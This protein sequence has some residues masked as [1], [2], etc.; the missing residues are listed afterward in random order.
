MRLMPYLRILICGLALQFNAAP[1]L[2]NWIYTPGTGSAAFVSFNSG[3]TPAGTGLCAAANTDCTATVPINTAGA[4]LFTGTTP[5]IVAGGGT[6]G[7]PGTAVMA[8]QGVSGGT[9]VPVSATQTTSPWIIAGA[10][11]AGSPG[12]AALTIQGIGSGTAV[13]ISGSVTANAGTNL[14]TSALATSANQ[15]TNTAT[16]AHTCSVA[17]YSELGCLGQIDD[18]V[19]AS[20]AAGTNLIGKVGIDQTTVGTT[21]GVSLAQIGSTTVL[22]GAGAVGAGAQRV[23]VGTDTATI[24][25]SAPGTAGTA[26]V[27]VV[28]V[29]GIAS[30]TPLLAN[31]GTATNWGVIADK[32]TFTASTSPGN[33]IAAE[34]TTGGATACA[35]TQACAVGMTAAR[36]LFTD[37]ES[38][39]ATALGTPVAWGSTPSGV[40]LSANV[41]CVVGC[42]AA[43]TTFAQGG[44]TAPT[45]ASLAGMTYNSGGV[46]PT[47][48]QSVALQSDAN[49]NLKV[50]GT[51]ILDTSAFSQPT[52]AG[53]G[54][55][56]L[57]NTSARSG[58][59]NAT[60]SYLSLDAAANLRVNCITGCGGSGGTASNF[61]SAF[62]T[63]GTAI[64]LTNGTNMVAWSA[65]SN[66]G[67]SPGAIAVPAVNADVTNTVAEN[68]TQVAGA[69]ISATN[70]LFTNISVANAAISATNPLFTN[71]SQ[72]SAALT[73]TNP[74][75]DR[76][77]AGATGGASTAAEIAPNNTTAV[78]VKGTAGTLYGI[79][80]YGIN[81]APAYLKI[82]NA[83]TAT[84]GSGTP[85]KR[86][87]I[88]AASTAA[89]GAGSN[90]TFGDV[91]VAFGTGITYCV[92]TGIGDTDTGAPTAANFLIN[93]DYL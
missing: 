24:A 63:A 91:G 32:G 16:T 67:T 11:T 26:S 33:L 49:G 10:G 7:T 88:P 89:N 65:A 50:V 1:A 84:C 31:P 87:M 71:L 62:T 82:Y 81:A 17:G 79:Q 54:V 20:I 70:P 4:Q 35:T 56:G 51:G 14:N 92:T 2:A 21:N 45:N 73:V 57:V 3:T 42:S 25:G 38:V 60:M 47:T 76:V 85:V 53:S 58:L 90:V 86:I 55:L 12:T 44:A 39:A 9:A 22:G 36:G 19:K 61:G 75:F 27:N 37:L 43:G 8:V 41:N 5:G 18:D 83:A 64:G 69:T 52:T 34:F 74:I 29:Q 80:V 68:I 6:A 15:A 72:A 23:A 48:G 77:V 13:P 78:V 66:Y 59:T 30:M 46:T 40:V 28:S 93:V